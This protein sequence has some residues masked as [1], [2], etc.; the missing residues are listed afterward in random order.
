MRLSISFSSVK[1]ENCSISISLRSMGAT[2][3][4]LWGL[5]VTMC[6]M[7]SMMSASRMGVRLMPICSASSLSFRGSPGFSSMVMIR[8]RMV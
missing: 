7:L 4:P 3:V 1:R 6:A 2:W 8:L 5:I